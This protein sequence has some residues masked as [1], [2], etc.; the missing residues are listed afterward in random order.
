M[1]ILNLYTFLYKGVGET[2]SNSISKNSKGNGALAFKKLPKSAD[3]KPQSP[4]VPA[5]SS[6][7]RELQ[8][9]Y[10]NAKKKRGLIAKIYGAVNNFLPL[11]ISDKKV[12]KKI[13]AFQSGKAKK[14]NVVSYIERYENANFNSSEITTDAL[15]TLAAVGVG[16]FGKKAKTFTKVFAPKYKKYATAATAAAS[17]LTGL[18]VKAGLKSID[19]LGIEK[20]YRKQ[21]NTAKKNT[22]AGAL[23]GISGYI[24]TVSPLLIPVAIG[25][26]T[27]ARYITDKSDDRTSPSIGDFMEKQ[28]DSFGYALLGLAGV[29][30]AAAKGHMN[31]AKIREAIEK[32]KINKNH[33]ISYKPPAGQLTEFQQL[34]RDIGYDLSVIIKGE[35]FDATGISKLDEDFL[36]ILLEKGQNGKIEDK[37]RKIE[38]ENIFLPKYLQTV[39]DI[40]DDKQKKICTQIDDLVTAHEKRKNIRWG[41]RDYEYSFESRGIDK[42]MDNLDEKGMDINGFKD[43]QQ[44]IAH[45]KSSCP[46]SRTIKQAQDM[47]N[48]EFGSIYKIEKLLGVGSIA[49]SYLG[50]DKN[51]K[52]VVIKIVKQHFLDSD[53]IARDKAKITRKIEERAKPDYSFYSSKQ[54]IHSPER[55]KYDENQVD[56]MFK[57]WGNEINLIEEATS[58][59]EI[60][61]QA[62]TFQPVGV[63]AAK[64]NIFIM[65]RAPGAQ[66][67]SSKFAEE[68][69]KADLNEDDFK[70]FVENYVQVYCDQL[71]SLPKKGVKAVQSDPHG[72]NILVDVAKIKE[73]RNGTNSKPITIIDYG[74][75]TKTEQSQAIKNL[76]NHIDYLIGNTDAIAEAMLEGADFGRNNKKQIIKELSEALKETMYNTDTK[77]DVDNPVK[78]FSTVNSFCLNFMQKK[79]IIPNACHINQMKAEETYIISNLG[80]LKNI[81]DSCNY[82]LAKAIDRDR[83]IKQLV[84][85]M[86]KAT[87]DAMKINPRLTNKEIAKRYKFFTRNSE[88]AI[89]CMG[90]NFGIV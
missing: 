61:E 88:E 20:N 50:K 16:F 34:A 53:K 22:I 51:S 54:T 52:E 83:I 36:K 67:D 39:V 38:E 2:M 15:A 86:T 23:A 81:A 66:L 21:Q 49:E 65:E 55:K 12:K 58:A 47:L 10:D 89:S 37:I 11:A 1:A 63:I 70:N 8:D 43:L 29:S 18:A 72:G 32:S 24:S 74:N 85:E 7:P 90:I 13:E 3:K 77:I 30:I 64:K 33:V 17:I 78:I 9:I 41:D 68:W 87:Q 80:C 59:K 19:S 69:K 6:P 42:A 25:I 60:G 84:S 5:I 31:V 82:D 4:T 56:N 46:V 79:N 44:I 28:K 26:N 71:F 75:T 14:D 35:K 40:P 57:V 27:F 62:L 48:A 45:I 73:L 76:F